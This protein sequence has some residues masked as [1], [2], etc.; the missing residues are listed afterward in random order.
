MR[1][2]ITTAVF[3]G[4]GRLAHHLAPAFEKAGI[5]VP[6]VC[7]R[8]LDTANSLCQL[9]NSARAVTSANFLTSGADLVVLCTPDSAIAD[10][11]QAVK[12]PPETMLVHT[13]GTVPLNAVIR[14]N[15]QAGVFYPLQTFSPGKKTDFSKIPICL[16]ASSAESYAALEQLAMA[17]SAKVV[18]INSIQRQQLHLAA[19]FACNF[20]NHMMALA[21]E[22]MQQN[23]LDFQ[24]LQPLVQET[25]EKALQLGPADSQTGP[26]SRNDE[27]TLQMHRQ[28]L[29]KNT[30]CQ[31]VYNLVT[32]SIQKKNGPKAE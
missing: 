29:K 11:A 31:Q 19:V 18:R 5:A 12:L 3:V 21:E 20:S 27:L 28:L 23:Q 32:E 9:L 24:L 10:M 13:S 17:I 6:L 22:I 25:F 7:S 2:K 16:E 30:F 14:P 4:A 8:S 1:K 26:A 15:A